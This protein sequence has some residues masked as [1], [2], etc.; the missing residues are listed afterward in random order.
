MVCYLTPQSA[1]YNPARLVPKEHIVITVD[2]QASVS[3]TAK[4]AV[5]G[6]IKAT[7]RRHLDFFLKTEMY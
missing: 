5:C 1:H 3:E 7:Q 2:P 4:E 6:R